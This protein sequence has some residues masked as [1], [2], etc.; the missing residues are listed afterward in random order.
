MGR[1]AGSAATGISDWGERP[2]PFVVWGEGALPGTISREPRS[3]LELAATIGRL[4]GVPQPEAA[5]G[6][7]LVPAEDASVEP[8]RAVA[9]A[10]GRALSRH[11]RGP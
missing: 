6:R 8:A 2:V 9:G 5:R 10:A 4:L 1:A 7:P 3:V 11:R